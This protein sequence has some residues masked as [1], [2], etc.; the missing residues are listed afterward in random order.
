LIAGTLETGDLSEQSEELMGLSE[1]YGLLHVK[2]MCQDYLVSR[3]D[4]QNICQLLAL[5]DLYG[6]ETLKNACIAFLG[7]R[8]KDV[9]NTDDWVEL[10]ERHPRLVNDVLETLVKTSDCTPPP[11]KRMR[12]GE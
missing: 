12:C 8:K 2:S 5:A 9:M 3:V 10:K 1:K 6:A 4:R 7:S 11:T